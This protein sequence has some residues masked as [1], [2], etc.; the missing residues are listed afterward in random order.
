VSVFAFEHYRRNVEGGKPEYNRRIETWQDEA[1]SAPPLAFFQKGQKFAGPVFNSRINCQ[2]C[3]N[4]SAYWHVR[5]YR[6][7]RSTAHTELEPCSWTFGFQF[8]FIRDTWWSMC[9]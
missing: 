5:Q 2:M 6:W 9:R 3:W 1:L 8:I 4:A 7:S